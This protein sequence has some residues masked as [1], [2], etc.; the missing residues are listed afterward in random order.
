MSL[1][2]L[3]VAMAAAAVVVVNVRQTTRAVP[4]TDPLDLFVSS[5][6][7]ECLAVGF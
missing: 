3:L 5:M 4:L 7:N 6:L 1:G 2:V